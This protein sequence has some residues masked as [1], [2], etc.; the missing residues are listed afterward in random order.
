MLFLCSRQWL[1][2]CHHLLCSSAYL[3]SGVVRHSH[4]AL[5][6]S[7]QNDEDPIPPLSYAFRLQL[8]HRGPNQGI[9]WREENKDSVCFPDSSTVGGGLGGLPLAGCILGDG[10]TLQCPAWGIPFVVSLFPAYAFGHSL[11]INPSMD[12]LNLHGLFP[13]GILIDT[14]CEWLSM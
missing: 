6:S 1:E 7:R 8:A 12:Y 11:F 3:S 13:A 14:A 5:C 2:K 4:P 10:T 9:G